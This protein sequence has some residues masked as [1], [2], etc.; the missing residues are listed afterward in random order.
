MKF[1]MSILI[2]GSAVAVSTNVLA[3]AQRSSDA[4]D[5]ATADTALTEIVVTGSRVVTDGMSSPTPITVATTEQILN[6]TPS[7]LSDALKK[8]PQF[9]GSTGQETINNPLSNSTGNVLNLRNFGTQRNLILFNGLRVPPTAANGT[10]D[11]N[12]LPQMLIERVEVVTGGASAVYGSDA[13][14]GV[15]NYVIDKKFTGVETLLQGGRSSRS[16]NDSWKAGIAA[17]MPLFQDRGHVMFSYEHYD[18]EGIERPESRPGGSEYWVAAGAGTAANPFALVPN[19]RLRNLTAGSVI[20]GG[21]ASILGQNFTRDGVLLP[22]VNGA[23]TGTNGTQSGGDGGTFNSAF[24]IAPLTTD[25]AF[26][27]FDYEF[28]DSV[29]AYV[30]ASYS[31]SQTDFLFAPFWTLGL[32]GT[33]LSGNAFLPAN[34]Q[35]ALDAAGGASFN[36]LRISDRDAGYPGTEVRSRVRNETVTL[37][38]DGRLFGAVDWNV[39]YTHSRSS[40]RV[41]NGNNPNSMK[42]AAAL[43]AVTDPS[44]GNVVCQVSLTQYAS[45]YPGCE[46]INLFGPTAAS[47]SAVEY[48]VDDTQYSLVNTMDN[49]VVGFTASP[50][51]TWAGPVRVSVSG[52]YRDLELRNRSSAEPNALPDCTGLRA[53]CSASVPMYLSYTVASVEASQSVREAAVE[54]L[55]PL[56]ADVPFIKA[57][58]LNAAARYTDYSTSGGEDTWKLGFNW[59]VNDDFRLRATRSQ[60]IRAPN[61]LDLYQPQAVSVT[62]YTDQ[63]TATS[64]ILNVYS[65]GNPDLV[66][67]V[68]QTLTI[69]AV[70]RPSW[71]PDLSISL[72]YYEIDLD[73]AIVGVSP[74]LGDIQRACEDSQGTSPY[75]SLYERPLPFS[76]RSSANY[77]TRLFSQSLN[78]ASLRTKGLDAE[79]GY[80]FDA[81]SLPGRFDVRLLAAY[82]PEFESQAIQNGPV[83]DYAGVATVLASS[84]PGFS[85]VRANLILSYMSD[86]FDVMLMERW[87]SGQDAYLDGIVYTVPDIP[88]YSYTDLTVGYSFRAM[89]NDARVFLSVQNLFDKNAPIIGTGADAPALRFP[90]ASGYDT[91]GRYFTVGLKAKF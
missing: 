72:D 43:D 90:T 75:C 56:I 28:S 64:G 71:L 41:V 11:I 25:Q 55:V 47:R 7:N 84:R 40:Q 66:P 17:G 6:A 30:Q 37:G 22:F 53:N 33:I 91:I 10:V 79:V 26:G 80:T 52:E 15:V 21:P 13:V 89:A 39:A 9:V 83:Q 2:G 54:A 65:Q 38:F 29:S 82:Q 32:P 20:V 1:L 8:L 78:V 45:L 3:Q 73:N 57:F 87:Q 34:V 67:E 12:T 23:P 5:A 51:S 42:F 50:F 85:K 27:R 62:G 60:D 31:E 69:G 48:I 19:G 86:T 68:A 46:P 44:T 58:D 77:P 18:V 49:F 4:N 70:W 61:L 14:T 88:S 74:V 63:H 59:E 76:D 81:A 36:I 16:D 35:A 24:L